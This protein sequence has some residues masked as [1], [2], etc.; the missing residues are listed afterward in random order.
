VV[1]AG[2]CWHWFDAPKAAAEVRRLLRPQGHAVIAHFDWV[3]LPGN[4][5]A[6]TE[7][8]ITARNPA[9]T[10]GGGTG[11]HPRW[12]ADLATAGFTGI[13]T[14]SFDRDV[15][16]TPEA[17]TG[18]IRASA[19]V[20]ASLGPQEVAEFSAEL[21]AL[22]RERFPGDVLHIPHRTWAVVAEPV[23]DGDAGMTASP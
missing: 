23:A 13:E 19:G 22:L 4:V 16:Y 17:W 1:S 21:S 18:R 9:W 8:L 7:D 10:M 6:A 3:P 12:L 5:A 11:L 15:P 2:Q 14:F 20:G